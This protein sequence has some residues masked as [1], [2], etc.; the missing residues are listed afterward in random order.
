VALLGK[1]HIAENTLAL[2]GRDGFARS[3]EEVCLRSVFPAAGGGRES[4]GE[5]GEIVRAGIEQQ[6]SG[7]ALALDRQQALELCKTDEC[8]PDDVATDYAWL[9]R[10]KESL[11]WWKRAVDAKSP[12][13]L[14]LAVNPAMDGLRGE[15]EYQFIAERVGF[16]K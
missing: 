15:R 12:W 2:G 7:G 4:A 3:G 10:N 6:L 1:N 9:G 16:P 11:E 13:V 14:D 5:E 8:V